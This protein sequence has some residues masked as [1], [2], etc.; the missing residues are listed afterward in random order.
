MFYI[1]DT[2]K[3]QIFK[4]NRGLKNYFYMITDIATRQAAV[5]DPAWELERLTSAIALL[6]VELKAILL[7]HSHADHTNLVEPLLERFDPEVVISKKEMDYYGY[8]CKNVRPV[9]DRD[10]IKLGKTEITTLLTPGHT[11]GSVCYLL[12]NSL[13]TGDTIFIEGCGMCTGNGG[14]AGNMFDSIQKIKSLV[15]PDVAVYPGHSYGKQPGYRLSHLLEEN[16]YFL[17]KDKDV[18]IKY[19]T[20][21][22]QTNLLS[23]K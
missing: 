6:N 3:I 15:R 22:N 7:T 1:K 23:F 11:V 8:N 18:F 20:R 12:S 5:V 9:R 2:Y 10:I 19:R 21:G 17:F 16:I 4:S 13:F 14:D